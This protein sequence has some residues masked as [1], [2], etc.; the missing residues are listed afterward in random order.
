MTVFLLTISVLYA[1]FTTTLWLTWLRM[2]TFQVQA[3]GHS[4]EPFITVVIPVRNE[5]ANLPALLADLNQQTYDRFEVIVADDASTD[6][7]LG[8]AQHF[9]ARF[10]LTALPLTDTR[11]ASPKKR[12]ITASIAAA[13]GT[14]IVTTD[15]DC[16]VGPQWLATIAGFYA[17]T[18]AKLI[19]G[20]VTFAT[21]HAPS[22]YLQTVE[23]SSLIGSGACTLALGFPT[24]C[25]GANLCYEK[26][27]FS[28]VGGFAGVD[29]LA[30]GDD[31]L[32]MHKIARQHP[33]GVRFLKNA[34]AIV[35]T[36]P[37]TSWR[38]FYQQRKRW[39]SKW[40]AYES[41]GPSVL[42]VFIFLSNA[43]G[44]LAV[45]AWLA[46]GVGGVVA[47]SVVLLKVLPEFLF[48]R[49]ILVFLQKKSA[50]GWIPPTQ[51][52]Y[53]F[54]VV[55]FGLAAQGKGFEWKGRKLS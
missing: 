1:F 38:A 53:P 14:L 9:P 39:A 5:A 51:L 30:S 13:R 3:S 49:Q 4:D 37:H 36:G 41:W 2:P 10:P 31:E 47:A 23:G 26:R 27:V 54:Y 35:R 7:T 28:E 15:G 19:S 8:I 34:G 25:N 48:L 17:Q 12:A 45:V 18:G 16:R 33:G 6:D 22:A 21:E 40:R 29:H 24:M 11:V 43:A 55:F 42:A 46:G 20:P 44:P 32:L 50:V 52:L